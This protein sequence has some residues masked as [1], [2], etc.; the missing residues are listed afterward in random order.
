LALLAIGV[1]GRTVIVPANAN[2][3]TFVA[4]W[5][6][7]A[8]VL[9]ADV[10]PVTLAPRVSD[11][12]A[13]ATTDT[14]AVLVVHMGGIVAASTGQL[15]VWC[16]DH[17]IVLIEDAAHAH[18]SFRDGKHAGTFGAVGAFSFFATKVM[19]TGEG[20]M[21]I[22]D[23][24]TLAEEIRLYRNLGKAEAWISHHTR[25]GTNGRLTELGAV[26]GRRQLARLD[27]FVLARRRV[28]DHYIQLLNDVPGVTLIRPGH[29]YSGY[30]VIVM[31]ENSIDREELKRRMVTSDVQLAG[32][33]YAAPLH[34][35]PALGD[36]RWQRF[37]GAEF[38]CARQICLPV[39]PTLDDER[40]LRV[41]NTL[42]EQLDAMRGRRV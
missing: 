20:G 32:E 28:A 17:D 8:Q 11:V 30:K 38:S 23:D 15:A 6:C 42:I 21:V 27:Q 14:A 2:F 3:A 1:R 10:D 22:T 4:A 13:V 24:S 18:G 16:A 36:Y 35:Q 41:A 5:R 9:L 19:S 34:H 37:P 39:Y 40:V 25:M 31:L 29:D 7:G 12:A 33:I 26:V